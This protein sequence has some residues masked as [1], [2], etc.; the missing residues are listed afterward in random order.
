MTGGDFT[1][2]LTRSGELY[3]WGRND[4]GQLGHG[5]TCDKS[6]PQEVIVYSDDGVPDPMVQVLTSRNFFPPAFFLTEDLAEE[7]GEVDT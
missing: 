6:R 5:Y 2:A 4:E 1:V 7:V 3:S